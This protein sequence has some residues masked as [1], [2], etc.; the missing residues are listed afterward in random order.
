[1][2]ATPWFWRD[3]SYQ[4]AT[5]SSPAVYG[6]GAAVFLGSLASQPP[7]R[8]RANRLL[9]LELPG[10]LG[11]LG[12]EWSMKALFLSRAWRTASSAC[13][14]GSWPKPASSQ[15][16]SLSR[17]F[18]IFPVPRA[19]KPP[20]SPSTVPFHSYQCLCS[21]SQVVWAVLFAWTSH[22]FPPL[23]SPLS[24]WTRSPLAA[25]PSSPTPTQPV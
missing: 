13:P 24:A 15:P 2:E 7:H 23:P 18:I 6:W 25:L 12:K 8:D 3:R 20:S 17:G 4:G 5:G 22:S 14:P 10:T 19:T 1:M 16:T 9:A 11:V 21:V